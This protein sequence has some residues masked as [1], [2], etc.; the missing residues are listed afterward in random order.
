[1]GHHKLM[2]VDDDQDLNFIIRTIL[3][4]AGFN[5]SSYFDA[6]SAL[7]NIKQEKPDIIMMDVMMPGMNGF[8]ACKKIKADPEICETTVFMLTAR[9]MG[10]DIDM[11]MQNKADFFIS[12]PFDNDYLIEKINEFISKKKSG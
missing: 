10:E 9:G 6:E 12:K 4:Q 3:E 1:M 8:D 11:A 7:K 2:I 5:I